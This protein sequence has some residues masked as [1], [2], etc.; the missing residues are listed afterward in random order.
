VVTPQVLRRCQAKGITDVL[1]YAGTNDFGDNIPPAQSIAS[2][3]SM[4]AKLHALD[5]NAVGSTLISNVNQAGTT[6][7]TYTAHNQINDYILTSGDFDSTADFY[8]KTA[9]PTNTIDGFPILYPNYRT[10]SDPTGTPDFLHLGRAG[11]QAEAD[12]LDIGFF[13][14][15]KKSHHYGK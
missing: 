5:I 6:D 8:T 13:V 11:A 15:P 4:V 7:A 9:D 12:T 3:Q 14:P 10:H 2:L 1:F